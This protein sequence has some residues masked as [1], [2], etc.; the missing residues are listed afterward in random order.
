MSLHAACWIQCL[1]WA[2]IK[3]YV[4][5]TMGKLQQTEIKNYKHS[6][7]GI[8]KKLSSK[9]KLAYLQKNNFKKRFT[10]TET[11]FHP[12]SLYNDKQL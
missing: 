11:G 12:G 3:Q 9:T 4:Y 7:Y 6:E 1:M 2:G 10:F 8:S 5:T